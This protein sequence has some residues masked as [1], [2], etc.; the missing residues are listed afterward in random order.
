MTHTY[1]S[2][3][4]KRK[5]TIFSKESSFLHCDSYCWETEENYC[6][7]NGYKA[8]ASAEVFHELWTKILILACISYLKGISTGNLLFPF[9]R[10]NFLFLLFIFLFYI[11]VLLSSFFSHFIFFFFT[12]SY[13][14]H[15]YKHSKACRAS[16]KN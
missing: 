16:E 15:F 9:Q 10:I 2:K 13:F 12:F 14:Y 6:S 4:K 8:S 11:F 5:T 3:S 7:D 1:L